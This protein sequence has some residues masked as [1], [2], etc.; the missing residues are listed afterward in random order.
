MVTFLFWNLQKRQLQS[1]ITKLALKYEVD[2]LMFAECEIAPADVLWALNQKEVLYH[3][4]DSRGCEKIQIFTKF[5]KEFIP[6]ISESSR[7]TIRHL[8]LPGAKNILLAV[9]HLLSKVNMQDASQDAECYLLSDVIKQAEQDIGH[10][11]T[12][13]VGDLNMNPFQA[14]IITAMGLHGVMTQQIAQRKPRT[15]QGRCYP[16]FYNPMWSLFG[17]A[18]PGP[19]A[20]YYLDRSEQ[21]QLFWHMLDQVLIRPDLLDCFDKHD[22]QILASDGELSFLSPSGQPN[23]KDFSDHLPLMFKLTL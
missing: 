7:L 15:V 9:T 2:I 10:S 4:A 19:P 23:R 22:L 3:Y 18:T 20:T 13:L 6:A 14:G 1:S 5:P 16:F 17:D 11:N 21:T 12:V 8:Q